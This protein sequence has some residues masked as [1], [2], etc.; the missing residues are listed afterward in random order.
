M[1]RDR[2]GVYTLTSGEHDVTLD[3]VDERLDASE[4]ELDPPQVVTLRGQHR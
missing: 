2:L 1:F 3:Q 4:R